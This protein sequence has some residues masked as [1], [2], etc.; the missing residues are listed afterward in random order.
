V[1]NL[2]G[3]AAKHTDP[4]AEIWVSAHPFEKGALIK[5]EDSG[6]G[7][8]AELRETVFQPFRQ[9][10]DGEN[11]PG[12]GIGLSLVARFA[13]LHGGR[14]WVDERPGG[15]ASFAVYLADG[16]PEPEEEDEEPRTG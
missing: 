2:L 10:P 16:E 5:V 15:G 14:A 9:G 12:V 3:N 11:V 13:Q 8:P 7:I 6:P 1:E 4:G